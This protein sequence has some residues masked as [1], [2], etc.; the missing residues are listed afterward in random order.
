MSSVR[1]VVSMHSRVPTCM[2]PSKLPLPLL[3]GLAKRGIACKAP[4]ERCKRSPHP[5]E[6]SCF[7]PQR[8]LSPVRHG[9][10]PCT[11]P[12]LEGHPPSSLGESQLA[13]LSPRLVPDIPTR[14]LQPV[15]AGCYGWER[16]QRPKAASS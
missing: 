3:N 9:L 7:P 1:Y 5:K 4:Q 2:V 8:P 16:A 6:S 10:H 15:L 11:S 14:E 12:A 13:R